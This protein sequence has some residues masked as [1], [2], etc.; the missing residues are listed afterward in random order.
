MPQLEE[1]ISWEAR[2][3]T[4]IRA[5]FDGVM[6]EAVWKAV[7]RETDNCLGRKCHNYSE[8][9]Y[10]VARERWK[11]ARLLVTNHALLASHMALDG[12]L[13]PDF[14]AAVIDEAH[15][16]PGAVLDAMKSSVPLNELAGLIRQAGRAGESARPSPRAHRAAR[17]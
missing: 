13:L 14:S 3:P 10:F 6:P 17:P 15:R 4:G 16:F 12:K 1:L 5:E 7:T 2:T 8:S 11:N 9:F